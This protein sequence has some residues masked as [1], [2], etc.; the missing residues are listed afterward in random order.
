MIQRTSTHIARS[1]T[2]MELGLGGLYSETALAAGITTDTADLIFASI[3]YKIMHTFQM[4][5]RHPHSFTFIRVLQTPVSFV[6]E[7][8]H[9][10]PVRNQL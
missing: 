7:L 2:L 3:P 10:P 9:Q 5:M 1:D 6:V 4:R 8:R